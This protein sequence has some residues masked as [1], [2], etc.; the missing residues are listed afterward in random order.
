LRHLGIEF[1]QGF[2]VGYPQPAEALA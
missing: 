2:L 1:G